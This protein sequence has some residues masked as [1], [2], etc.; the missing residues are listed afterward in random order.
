MMDLL[1]QSW[2]AVRVLLVFTVIL[3]VL[4]PAAGLAAAQVLPDRSQGSLVTVG[5]EVV[6]S[7]LIGQGFDGD[8]WFLPR[9]SAAGDGYDAMAS[10]GS[11]FGPNNPDLVA[12]VQQR[13]SEVAQREGVSEGAVPADAVTASG[14]GLD[15]QISPEYAQLQVP[16]VAEARG[17]TTEQVEQLVDEATSPAGL[18]V[19]GEPG[20][21][22]LELNA[23]LQRAQ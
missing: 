2:A 11:N 7:S 23:A 1:R 14:S 16:R 4:Y 5:G 17:L 18:R 19:L 10:S 9:P 15:P 21:N 3:G 20:V 13:R 8:Q 6:G 12:Q 22:V